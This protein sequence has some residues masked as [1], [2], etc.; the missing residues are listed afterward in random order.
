MEAG[1][2]IDGRSQLHTVLP[3]DKIPSRYKD[4]LE[5]KGASEFPSV[6]LLQ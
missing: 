6:I 2:L 3:L 1:F 5:W 4:C